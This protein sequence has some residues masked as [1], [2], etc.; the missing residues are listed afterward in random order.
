[1]GIFRLGFLSAPD[2]AD[3]EDQH[4]R[5]DDGNEQA[6]QIEACHA[7]CAEETEEPAAEK[8]TDDADDDVGDRAHFAVLAGEDAGDPACQCAKDEPDKDVHVCLRLV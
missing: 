7:L 1:M 8:R 6:L 2:K 4:H 3:Q 5:A